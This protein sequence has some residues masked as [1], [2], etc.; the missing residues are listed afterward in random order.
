M[1]ITIP[2]Q[3]PRYAHYMERVTWTR[4]FSNYPSAEGWAITVDLAGPEAR[5]G[6]G[7]AGT[8]AGSGLW[9]LLFETVDKALGEYTWQVWATKTG[10]ARTMLESGVFELLAGNLD[11][12]TNKDS[13][14][15]VS[16]MLALIQ[17]R[18]EGRLELDSENYSVAGRSLSRIPMAELE[19]MERR[20]SRRRRA[21]LA[22]LSRGVAP[23]KRR[24]V[25]RFA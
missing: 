22:A 7:V 13:S 4:T 3:A 1:A 18:L 2:N 20:Y 6:F 23:G 8:D 5:D 24:I 25:A 9:T 16:R 17:A 19:T 12:A 11:G 10:E 14:T 15:H 21:E